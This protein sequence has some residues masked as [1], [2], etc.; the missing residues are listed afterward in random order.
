MT[1]LEIGN[2]T[3]E[4]GSCLENLRTIA[5]HFCQ[6]T[7]HVRTWDLL[8][9]KKERYSLDCDVPMLNSRV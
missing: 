7:Y 4:S 3:E 8:N 9:K 2:D 6:N 5:Q 1:G